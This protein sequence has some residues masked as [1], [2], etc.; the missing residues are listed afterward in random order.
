MN[1]TFRSLNT[2]SDVF[3]SFSH[4]HGGTI[5]PQSPTSSGAAQ[6]QDAMLSM[7]S[8]PRATTTDVKITNLKKTVNSF[9]EDQT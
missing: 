1:V 6:I 7:V 5:S 2:R 8:T 4:Q 3:K 9:D